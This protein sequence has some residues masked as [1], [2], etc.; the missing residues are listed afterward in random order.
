MNEKLEEARD[1][2]VEALNN[3]VEVVTEDTEG[4]W[5]YLLGDVVRAVTQS[6]DGPEVGSIGVVVDSD[7]GAEDGVGVAWLGGFDRGH[8]LNVL[9]HDSTAGWWVPSNHITKVTV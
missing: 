6:D 5:V 1:A 2:L 4:V 3:F 9:P 8:C 7:P